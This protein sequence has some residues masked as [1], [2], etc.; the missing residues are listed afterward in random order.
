M[1]LDPY[2]VAIYIHGYVLY[3]V[4]LDLLQKYISVP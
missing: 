4:K 1:S 3:F 2:I